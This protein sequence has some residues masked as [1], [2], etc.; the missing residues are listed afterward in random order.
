MTEINK[1][2]EKMAEVIKSVQDSQVFHD[3]EADRKQLST[4]LFKAGYRKQED[5]IK[6]FAEKF[7]EYIKSV[8]YFAIVNWG[9]KDYK[10]NVS[11]ISE[12]LNTVSKEYGID[13]A[14]QFGKEEV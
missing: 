6:E 10:M 3:G 9:K 11:D 8:N 12:V 7:L 13:L 14:E 5:T 4:A 2:I 1:E